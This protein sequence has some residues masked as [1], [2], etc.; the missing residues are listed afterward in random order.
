ML[1]LLPW[2]LLL[3][4][5]LLLLLSWLLLLFK[6]KIRAHLDLLSIPR[7]WGGK[8]QNVVAETAEAGEAFSAAAAAVA[9]AETDLDVGCLDRHVHPHDVSLYS[10]VRGPHHLAH[11]T[12]AQVN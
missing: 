7:L 11:L 5:W 6:K 12:D 2:L 1:L 4:S 8:C 10:F 9:A 3:L